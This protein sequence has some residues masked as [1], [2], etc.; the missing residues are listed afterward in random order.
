MI[1]S[2][3]L[4]PFF[5]CLFLVACNKAPDPLSAVEYTLS[6]PGDLSAIAATPT[7]E[8]VAVGGATWDEGVIA[9]WNSAIATWA[10][11]TSTERLLLDVFYQT[12]SNR[13]YTLGLGG[14][15]LFRDGETAWEFR[16]LP[17]WAQFRGGYFFPDG[18]GW[19][20]SGNAWKNGRLTHLN[21]QLNRDTF[22]DFEEELDVVYFIDS[23]CGFAAGFGLLLRTDDKGA[24]WQTSTLGGDWFLGL[25]FPEPQ[26]G[27]LAG[28]AGSIYKTND[29]GDNW[30]E[31]RAG[32]GIFTPD[33]RLRS[34]YFKNAKVGLAVGDEG[35]V[36]Q[37]TDGGETWLKIAGLPERDW[38]DVLWAENDWWLVGSEATILQLSLPD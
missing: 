19:I 27:Y 34:L 18:S 26:V 29:G 25:H 6:V 21:T 35:M 5:L 20:V 31:L 11:D 7:G 17:D 2:V 8:L 10:V 38:R 12:T 24:T 23:L 1:R 15:F 14:D 36:R 28:Y 22:L 4:L 3:T 30:L 32:G 37:T 33:W 16:R 13:M 9:T